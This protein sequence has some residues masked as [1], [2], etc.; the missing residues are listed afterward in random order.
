MTSNKIEPPGH[1]QIWGR[2]LLGMVPVVGAGAVEIWD[3]YRKRYEYRAL[4]TLGV[5]GEKVTP[6]QLQE[7]LAESEDLDAV[8]GRAIQAAA[9]SGLEAKRLLLGLVVADAV[10]DDAMIDDA[11][12]MTDVLSQIEAPHVRC[13]EDIWR[14][15]QE[16]ESSGERPQAARGAER[17]I[18]QRILD[19]GRKYPS[20]LLQTL[21]N[22]SL[23][24]ARTSWDQG[25]DFVHGLTTF[26]ED[27]LRELHGATE[28]GDSSPGAARDG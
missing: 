17:E 27:F 26:G 4:Q 7:R 14:V 22:L 6:E 9:N 12:L 3:G 28:A 16:V 11:I 2:A 8:F 1:V 23:L 10:L 13:L 5:I 21:V 20:P 25:M 24:D 19:V 18:N 15:Q